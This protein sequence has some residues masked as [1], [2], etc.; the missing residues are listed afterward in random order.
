MKSYQL[1]QEAV[2][3]AQGMR[4]Q[5][6]SVVNS[7]I[8]SAVQGHYAD[9]HM[10]EKTKGSRLWISPLMALY[11]FFDLRIVAKR[12]LYLQN[13]QNTDTFMEA[14]MSYM[15]FCEILRRRPLQ[16]IPLP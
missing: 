8:V 13:L 5:D 14:M 2:S 6:P 15:E 12:N 10:T 1:Y 4:L 16:R 7:S 11:W 9:Y 3:Y